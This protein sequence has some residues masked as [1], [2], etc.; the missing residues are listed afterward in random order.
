MEGGQRWICFLVLLCIQMSELLHTQKAAFPAYT[1]K[2]LQLLFLEGAVALSCFWQNETI[3]TLQ[4]GGVAIL[5]EG[6]VELLK[7]LCLWRQ[8]RP[9]YFWGIWQTETMWNCLTSLKSNSGTERRL[10]DVE[11]KLLDV[12]RLCLSSADDC[13]G[14]RALYLMLLSFACGWI[15]AVFQDQGNLR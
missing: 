4:T 13:L 14:E 2:L 9:G 7:E 5:G 11:L 10:L 1:G 15:K 3:T 8:M 6:G 12:V